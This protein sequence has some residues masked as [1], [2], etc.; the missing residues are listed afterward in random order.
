[1]WNDFILCCE[2]FVIALL[3]LCAFSFSE[4]THGRTTQPPVSVFANITEV[5][6]MKDLASDAYHNFN[7][8]YSEYM[9][10]ARSGSGG[11][12][13]VLAIAKPGR[14]VGAPGSGVM[15]ANGGADGGGA[16]GVGGV[17][18]GAD[19]GDT[20]LLSA[21][22]GLAD[23]EG[24]GVELVALSDADARQQ[25]RLD[26][27]HDP[28]LSQVIDTDSSDD[29]GPREM[30]RHASLPT[31]YRDDVPD[32]DVGDVVGRGASAAAVAPTTT[33][34]GAAGAGAGVA[35][36][37][38]VDGGASDDSGGVV[39]T[40][41]APVSVGDSALH[42]PAM[43]SVTSV[44]STSRTVRRARGS[45]AVSEESELI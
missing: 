21:A 6:S 9:P 28:D 29:D 3:H 26:H 10:A 19:G 33:G 2:M 18:V 38:D 31:A 23:G 22:V 30:G 8:Q 5:L 24:T 1:M 43:S 20:A 7:S 40:G 45:R 25:H 15:P 34:A 4:F 17:G 44:S 27:F 35:V 36:T 11:N 39:L 13:A 37:V 16:A 14:G 41:L 32:V 42:S 12:A